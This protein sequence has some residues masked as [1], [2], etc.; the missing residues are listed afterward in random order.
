MH[1]FY[2]E[3]KVVFRKLSPEEIEYYVTSYKPLDKAGA[4]GIQEWIGYIGIEEIEGSFYNVMGL[5]V[6][7]LYQELI[8]FLQGD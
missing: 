5:P 7:M 1:L 6:Q 8:S 2:S 4:Y 3:S